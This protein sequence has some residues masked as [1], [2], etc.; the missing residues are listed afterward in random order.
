MKKIVSYGLI[1]VET[2]KS[3]I[4]EKF[5]IPPFSI[6]DTMQGNW[7][8]R[9]NEWKSLGIKSELGRG[10]NLTF[11]VSD[12]DDS[13]H[14]NKSK[15]GKCLPEG[16]GEKY[17]RKNE[18]ATSIFDPVLCELMYTWF[19]PKNGNKVLD[20]FAGGSVRGVVAAALGKDYTGI[21]LRQ[22]QIDANVAQFKEIKEKFTNINFSDI[23]WICGNSLK[24]K[25]L[26]GEENKFD[27]LFSCP[28][29]YDLEVYSDKEDDLSNLSSY[30][31]FFIM[32]KKIIYRSCSLLNDDSFACFVVGD[33]RDKQ[34]FYRNFVADTI[35]AFKDAGLNY[36]NELILVNSAGS[37]PI[38]INK[39]FNSGRK[40]GKR[41]Q[42][43]LVFYKG[44][45]KNIKDKFGDVVM[46]I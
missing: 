37:L 13:G 17:G 41:H 30:D 11:G 1:D 28:P 21:D 38:R 27:L 39:Q 7:R 2:V 14:K 15:F 23:N 25:K 5:G 19:M 46:E 42:N 20:C 32:Y 6:L 26:V 22:E 45:P 16:F 33:I 24:I 43:V 8:K 40:I 10:D 9:V 29:Y 3:P 44:D 34:G 31:D 18:Q 4:E 36:Y 35:Q 12:L